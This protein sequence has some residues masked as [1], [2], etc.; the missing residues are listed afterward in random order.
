[1]LIKLDKG[2]NNRLW[3]IVLYIR[4]VPV[5][6]QSSQTIGCQIDDKSSSISAVFDSVVDNSSLYRL[7]KCS[8]H[9]P[10]ESGMQPVEFADFY[11]DLNDVESVQFSTTGV[12]E[13]A[14][15]PLTSCGY[16]DLEEDWEK[17]S[18]AA[19]S[20][21]QTLV[22]NDELS[23]Y[24]QS[25]EDNEIDSQDLMHVTVS[26]I[27]STHSFG[28]E[29]DFEECDVELDTYADSDNESESA[30]VVV[31][32]SVED[33]REFLSGDKSDKVSITT[34]DTRIRSSTDQFS[35]I[36]ED[37]EEDEEFLAELRSSREHCTC[38]NIQPDSSM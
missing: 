22:M 13:L 9:Q 12:G 23:T 35:T 24:E 18:Q 28:C 4:S 29:N 25:D 30:L 33:D 17:L 34:G 8:S 32:D 2:I 7:E 37:A 31:V 20:D 38:E 26:D 1:M 15:S 27:N 10:I 19:L 16:I 3:L 11:D 6:T 14:I 21:V 36:S 5:D